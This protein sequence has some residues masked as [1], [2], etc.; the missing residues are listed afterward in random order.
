MFKVDEVKAKDQRKSLGVGLT[1]I[2]VKQEKLK[3]P[4]KQED[5]DWKKKINEINQIYNKGNPNDYNK[6]LML[7]PVVQ[8]KKESIGQ[9]LKHFKEDL[10]SKKKDNREE[11]EKTK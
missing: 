8:P 6:P 2:S 9:K 7:Q 3:E 4:A 1:G 5:L 11:E 10:F